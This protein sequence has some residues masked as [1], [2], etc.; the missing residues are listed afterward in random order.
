MKGSIR[1]GAAGL[2]ALAAALHL[3]AAFE[4]EHML[5]LH[6]FLFFILAFASQAVVGFLVW[7][8]NLW[9]VW[10]ALLINV[11]AIALFAAT[12]LVPLPGEEM[13]EPVEALGV[14]TKV[15]EIASLPLLWRLL[16]ILPQD[17]RVVAAAKA[18]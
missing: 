15:V 14:V 8:Q 18:L 10:A 13:P 11:G 5:K 16:R 2:L 17:A 9:G 7:R 1:Y 6:L 4:E 3:L 12:R